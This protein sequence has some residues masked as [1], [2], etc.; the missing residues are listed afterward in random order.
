VTLPAADLRAL[1]ER[2]ERAQG[3]DRE[4]D[5]EIAE[6]RGAVPAGAF[7][8]YGFPEKAVWGL[9]AYNTWKAPAYTASLD[10]ALTLVPEGWHVGLWVDPDGTAR[11]RMGN[12]ER[13]IYAGSPQANCA[14]PALA[15]C[16]ASLRAR[17]GNE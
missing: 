13:V 5:A 1:A 9:D 3:P 7:R 4:L 14:T 10:D 15:L 17:A 2:C 8:M 11:V 6:A 16:A 12:G